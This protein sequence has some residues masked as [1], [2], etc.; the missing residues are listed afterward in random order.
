M[1]IWGCD[2]HQLAYTHDCSD[3]LIEYEHEFNEFAKDALLHM[4]SPYLSEGDIKRNWK[5]AQQMWEIH[6][7]NLI[8]FTAIGQTSL[9]NS[10]QDN[11]NA[12]QERDEEDQEVRA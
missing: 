7:M 8:Q 1:V 2:T 11:P 6:R 3:C 12:A 9:G 10:I 4:A 5:I